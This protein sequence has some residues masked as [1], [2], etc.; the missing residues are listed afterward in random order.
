M[1]PTA[2]DLHFANYIGRLSAPGGPAGS[3]LKG[4][5][6]DS[7]ECVSQTW[8]PGLEAIFKA[9]HG[10]ALRPWLPALQGWVIDTP[11]R[12]ERFL[13]DWRSTLSDL[14]TD[15]FYGE[16]A[17]LARKRGITTNF[18]T[19]MGD[20]VS[21]D[22]LRYMSKPDVPMCEYW[23]PDCPQRGGEETKP[24]LPTASAAHI[25]GKKVVAAESLTSVDLHWDESFGT[26][27][28][29]IDKALS[30]GVNQVVFHT[31][32]HN[33]RM[34]AVPGT[35][36]GA[37]IGSPFLRGQTWWP[38][39]RHFTDY[40]ARCECMLQTGRPANDVLWFLGDELDHK[41]RQDTP[42]PAGYKFDY[43][44]AD[45][46]QNRLRTGKGLLLNPEGTAW[47]LLWLKENRRT[48]PATLRAILRLLQSGAKMVG[49]PAIGALFLGSSR[50][51]QACRAF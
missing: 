24:I 46:L 50:T 40:V 23:Y 31:F 8:T 26:W 33:P 21:G 49:A 9:K 20:V 14:I 29:T 1:D 47:K 13:R 37:G 2:A 6:L 16:M 39:M 25:Y 22:I 36:F 41:P 3:G 45:V 32:T 38:N 4:M 17:S 27:K 35:S 42:F 18:E 28:T 7:W 48:T 34:G 12:T 10:Y 15:G 5:V 30:L 11:E 43:C 51:L 19:A 44:N